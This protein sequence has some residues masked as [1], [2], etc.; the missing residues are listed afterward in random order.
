MRRL[1]FPFMLV[2]LTFSMFAQ[3]ADSTISLHENI[4]QKLLKTDGKLK[5]GGYG[6]IHYNQPLSKDKVYNKDLD[7]HRMVMLFGYQFNQRTQ[8]I[9]EIEFEHVKEVYVEQAFLQYKLNNWIN[10]KAG[11]LLTPMGIINEYHEPVAFNGVERPIIDG[12]IVPTTWREIGAGFSGNVLPLS[13]KY[14]A[15]ITNGFSSFD[16]KAKLNG[17]N[18]LRSGRQKGAESFMSSPDFAAKV[19][20]YGIR[21]L[22]M[23]ISGYFGPTQSSLYDGIDRNNDSLLMI[24]DSSVVG[25][26]MLGIDARYNIGGLQFRGQYYLTNISNTEE[27]NKFTGVNGTPNDL[28]SSLTGYYAELG[29]NILKHFD[30]SEGMLIPF[31]RYEYMNMHNKVDSYLVANSSYNKNIITAGLTWK[32]TRDAVVKADL[33]FIESSNDKITVFN[34]G[35][36]VMF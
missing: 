29:Y 13:L 2:L 25:I 19:E 36:G 35:V 20:Y 17:S 15:Y 12:K 5:I 34:A 3:N 31:V 16:G 9:S 7:V 30:D 33:Q 21:G 14:Q 28:G 4:A 18:G 32:I 8:F 23:G 6:E 27:Y 24:A 1:L 10:L 11:L 22:N 26:S